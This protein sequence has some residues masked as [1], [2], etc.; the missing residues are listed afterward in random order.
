MRGASHGA[1]R[2][3]HAAPRP[4]QFLFFGGKG[5]VGKT[6]CAAA[7]AVASA[8]AG[9]RVLAVSTDPA[10][11]LGDALGV[12]LTSRLSRIDLGAATRRMHG[13]HSTGSL[14]GVEL[15]APRAFARWL[16]DHR[17]ALGDIVE[18]G[19][20]L[21]REDV[22]ALLGLSMPGIDELMGLI[23][24][25]RL[26]GASFL[27]ARGAPPPR[28]EDLGLEPRLSA[29][30]RHRGAYD[31]VVV[32]TAP[33]GHTLRLLAAPDTV[34]AVAAVLE[35]MQREHRLMREQLARVGRPEAADRLIDLLADQARETATLLS[36]ARRSTFH[37]V[38]LPEELSLAESEDG[39]AALARAHI[40]IAEVI[41]N[42]VTPGGPACPICD[43]RRADER[44]VLAEIPRRLGQRRVRAVP[45]ESKEPRGVAALARIGRA[46]AIPD[47]RGRSS[48]AAAASAHLSPH[49]KMRPAYGD[50][51]RRFSGA[52]PAD[53]NAGRGL[54]NGGRAGPAS[55]D[56]FRG[57]RLLLFGGKGGVGKTTCAAAAALGLARADRARRVLLLSTDPA[58]SLG[59]VFGIAAGDL[60]RSVPGAPGNL[61]VRELDAPAVLAARRGDLEAALDEIGATF[62]GVGGLSE[63]AARGLMDLAPPGIDELLGLIEI[64]RLADEPG[65]DDQYDLIV[66]D[67]AP[68]GHALRLLEMPEAARDW[69]QVLMRI[70]L[71]YRELARP[72]RLAAELLDLSRS[73]RRLQT[74]LRDRE[75]ARFIVVTRAA[76]MP[77]LETDRLIKRLRRLKLAVPAVMIN[78]ATLAPGSC[79]R[80]RATA[81]AER[82]AIAALVRSCA[83]PVSKRAQGR[84]GHQ[85]SPGQCAIILTP[86]AAPPPRGVRALEEWA[87]R[88]QI[89]QS[90]VASHQSQTSV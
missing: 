65:A 21:D 78:A 10:H 69:V 17:Q 3:P 11:S 61:R 4:I 80:C 40:A 38:M 72:G 9:A 51:G 57:A 77:R 29:S 44:R 32:D 36:D 15:D 87:G 47:G 62:G 83:A 30:A 59:D 82:V 23:E 13:S 71:K 60:A 85:A 67:T 86:L 63:E 24:I 50:V 31:L 68:T 34:A 37:W 48:G 66:L 26:A 35:A 46:L 1:R 43:R 33:T 90:S 52:S 39:V 5:G 79:P 8:L 45:A 53:S 6:T 58:H 16:A 19:T 54:S 81:A 49:L 22:E 84:A 74:L 64:T 41:V 76:E 25:V 75:A 89:A 18:H 56:A 73:V 12:R 20:W 27:T 14:S 42:R 88:W 70:L 28:A 2:T 55:I 7:R